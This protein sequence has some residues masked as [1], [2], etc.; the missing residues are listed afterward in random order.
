MFQWNLFVHKHPLHADA[1]LP[2]A[3]QQFAAQQAARLAGD[4]PFRRCLLSYLLNL[5]RFRLLT[6]QQLHEL[7]RSLPPVA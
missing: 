5:W 1:D 7:T 6:P 2:A 4:G 3:V